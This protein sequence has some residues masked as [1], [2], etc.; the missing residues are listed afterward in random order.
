M[1]ADSEKRRYTAMLTSFWKSWTIDLFSRSH[2]L[3]VSRLAYIMIL[4]VLPMG[5]SAICWG[6]SSEQAG[7]APSSEREGYI[8]RVDLPL[9]G[10][11]DELVR[12]QIAKIA[13]A[14]GNSEQRPV[15]VLEFQAISLDAVG[16]PQN[17]ELGTRGSQFER[18][19]SLARYLTSPEASRVR[20]IAY[21]PETVEGHAVLPV[22]ACEEI[23]AAP[24]AELGRAA[25]DEPA[26]ATIEGAYRDIVA[27]RATLP[28]A[29]VMAMLVPASEVYEL[30]LSE[31]GSL[32]TNRAEAVRLR[33]EGK[34]LKETQ[35]WPGGGLAAF[36]GQQL[37]AR[38]WIART[39]DESSELSASLGISGS[40][41]TTRQLPREWKAVSLTLT[42]TLNRG[43]VNQLIRALGDA[44]D[45]DDVNLIVLF[46]EQCESNFAEASRL[47][48][49]LTELGNADTDVYTLSIV[50][51]SVLG[52]ESLIAVACDE[53]VLLPGSSLGGDPASIAEV[54][55]G[56]VAQRVLDDLA[57]R[58]GRPLPLMAALADASIDVKE[59]VH[60]GNGRRA[61]FTDWQVANQADA[62]MWLAKTTV[63]SG[64]TIDNEIALRYRLVDSL[65]DSS[66]IALSRLGITRTPEELS[67]PW[68]DASIQMVLAQPWIP[69]LLLTIG[70]FAL[71]AELGNPGIGVGGF[72]S[73]VCFLGFFWIEGLNGNVEWLE[74][75]LFIAGL[76][77]LAIELFALPGFGIFGIGGLLMV[78]VSV[79]LA[80]QTF[81]WP[82][83]SAQLS[84]FSVNLFW[85]AC[86]ALGGMIGLLFMHKQLERLPMFRWVTLQP[87]GADDLEEL[88]I[89]ESIVHL[90]HL[91]GQE[92]L[93]TTRL[94]PSGKA[95]FGRDLV[96]VIGVGAMID[97]GVPVR[98][99]E[100]RGNLILVEEIG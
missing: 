44:V 3:L 28:E 26:D 56:S 33:D 41:R 69:R 65:E 50:T 53:A 75:L 9:I 89:R 39:V 97:E 22:L 13:N 68:L 29:V 12:Q 5:V 31:G 57:Q 74:I 18:C 1:T 76:V 35:L 2:N 95:Q 6:Q 92:G 91:L 86:L 73:A 100:V 32:V 15:I 34:V 27:R 49:A 77:A 42:G 14:A 11:R 67:A 25:V 36:N 87:S 38:R 59:F 66:A 47:A 98:V 45:N 96:A 19:L 88:D 51:E 17:A 30:E 21:L 99:V 58:T 8:I 94:N 90:D 55:K 16:E 63:A 93:T 37:R 20:L 62:N 64:G 54:T 43:R 23:I 83:T 10:D 40:L 79:V 71:M 24:A 61:I 81:V 78:F 85:V 72:L 46:V 70:F 80:S 84:E 60:Q 7:E 52:P 48:S 82:T 4:S